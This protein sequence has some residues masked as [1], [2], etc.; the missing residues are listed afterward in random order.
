M[1]SLHNIFLTS[2]LRSH[3]SKKILSSWLSDRLMLITVLYQQRF[4]LTQWLPRRRTPHCVCD[5][6]FST[7]ETGSSRTW[8][9]RKWPFNIVFRE[10]VL[11]RSAWRLATGWTVQ[12]SNP[13]GWGGNIFRTHPAS[14]H[15]V[16]GLFPEVQRPA[17]EPS[18]C[19]VIP[20]APPCTGHSVSAIETSQFILC[21]KIIPVV[22]YVQ[23]THMRYSRH[24]PAVR[25]ETTALY[26]VNLTGRGDDCWALLHQV[27]WRRLVASPM[28]HLDQR[29]TTTSSP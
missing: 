15:W 12:C 10:S 19:G 28:H 23:N 16:P 21:R 4:G 5:Y 26:T 18:V 17:R 2:E 8:N 3:E 20:P 29:M 22:R 11:K 27:E 7:W 6:L 25:T 24:S 9:T 14:L 1:A 13:S